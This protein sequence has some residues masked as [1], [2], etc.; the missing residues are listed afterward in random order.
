MTQCALQWMAQLSLVANLTQALIARTGLPMY[1]TLARHDSHSLKK[2][3]TPSFMRGSWLLDIVSHRNNYTLFP[4]KAPL[5]FRQTLGLLISACLSGK[6]RPWH[7]LVCTDP[8][9]SSIWAMSPVMSRST[10]LFL[11]A[12]QIHFKFARHPQHFFGIMS[13]LRHFQ[14][15]CTK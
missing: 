6:S 8:D 12:K 9:K 3:M 10:T 15:S 2:M 5:F 11:A 1:A 14:S 13:S 7:V 4:E